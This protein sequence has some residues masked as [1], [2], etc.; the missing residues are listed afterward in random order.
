MRQSRT[1]REGFLGLFS[2]VGLIVF[3]GLA[4]WLSGGQLGQNTYTVNVRFQNASGIKEGGAVNYRGVLVGTVSRI[5]PRPN[6]VEVQLRINEKARIPVGSII[7]IGRSGLLGEA[8]VEITPS[9][10]VEDSLLDKMSPLQSTCDPKVIVCHKSDIEGASNPSV[11]TSLSRLAETFADPAFI[12]KLDKTLT[13]ATVLSEEL[14]KASKSLDKNLNQISQETISTARSINKT[15]TDA[16]EVSRNLNAVLIENRGSINQ[17]IA[18]TRQLMA[19]LNTV[20]KENRANISQSILSVQKT[21]QNIDQLATEIQISVKQ[22]SKFLTS[23][24]STRLVQNLNKLVANAT[25][26]SENLRDISK[27]INDP[28]I[29]LTLQQTL[30]SARSTFENSQKIT[31]DLDELTGDPV[32]RAKIRRLVDGLGKVVSSTNQIEEQVR[33][34]QALES[35]RLSIEPL[36]TRTEP[37]F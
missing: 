24:E 3:G 26:T 11:I 4:F 1:T 8:S 19:S 10:K 35:T 29:L 15:A 36:N 6:R 16:S 32:F 7:D 20:I 22:A 30:E 37:H 33:L 18:E 34:S 13:N 31:A 21:S 9:T 23:S 28:K 27:S 5:T 14:A 2:L 25:E 17:T 12:A